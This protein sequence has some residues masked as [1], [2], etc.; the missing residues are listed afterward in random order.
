MAYKGDINPVSGVKFRFKRQYA[1]KVIYVFLD[2]FYSA[3]FPCPHLG[4]DVVENFESLLA[5]PFGDA[6]IEAGVIHKD[7]GMGLCLKNR[8]FRFLKEFKDPMEI[9]GD[10]YETHVL[11]IA[12][13]SNELALLCCHPIATNAHEMDWLVTQL[14]KRFDEIT[15][16]KVTGGFARNAKQKFGHKAMQNYNLIPLSFDREAGIPL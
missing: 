14:P 6:Q 9:F 13:M 7:D 3:F 11:R 16:M 10:G 4:R 12:D 5:C 2:D 8:P 1:K 15:A